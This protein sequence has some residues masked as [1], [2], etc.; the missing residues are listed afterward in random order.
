MGAPLLF[1]RATLAVAIVSALTFRLIA[2]P[3]A[4]PQ[5]FL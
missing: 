1:S 4:V 5:N 3:S 2:A